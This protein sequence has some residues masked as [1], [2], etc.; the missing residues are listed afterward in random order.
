MISGT[1]A[2]GVK[3]LAFLLLAS[4]AE[5]GAQAGIT[6]SEPSYRV[7]EKGAL[8][9]VPPPGHHFNTQA[10]NRVRLDG[11]DLVLRVE[12]PRITARLSKTAGN[13]E[14]T[15]FICDA[16]K[17]YCARKVLRFNLTPSKTGGGKATSGKPEPAE[18]PSQTR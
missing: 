14:A 3:L 6:V 15:T 7:L 2:A 4:G 18:P 11:K 10:P 1:R 16:A 8:E 17:S 12:E 13:V 5:V 9:L